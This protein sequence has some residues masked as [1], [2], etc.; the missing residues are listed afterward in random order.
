MDIL[1]VALI[2]GLAAGYLLRTFF[3][4]WKKGGEGCSCSSCG[5][6]TACCPIMREKQ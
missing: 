1:I 3:R 6:C 5:S 4:K 2:V